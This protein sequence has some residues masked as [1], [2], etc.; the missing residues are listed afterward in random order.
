[1]RTDLCSGHGM[2]QSERV[3][4]SLSDFAWTSALR[5]KLINSLSINSL[6]CDNRS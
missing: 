3:G 1:M 2:F 5:E 6:I 4:V